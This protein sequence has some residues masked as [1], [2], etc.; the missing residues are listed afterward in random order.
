MYRAGHTPVLAVGSPALTRS[1]QFFDGATLVGSGG[2]TGNGT[3]ASLTLSVAAGTHTYTAVYPGDS[4]YGSLTFGSV[5]V[6]AH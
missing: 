5:T 4:Y 2:I 6:T 3:A 1:V